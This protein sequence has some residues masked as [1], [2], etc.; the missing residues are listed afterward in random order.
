MEL[1][2]SH[3]DIK[4]NENIFWKLLLNYDGQ[5]IEDDFLKDTYLNFLLLVRE[6]SKCR[7]H[8]T[9]QKLKEEIL[10]CSNVTNTKAVKK[11]IEKKSNL[12]QELKDLLSDNEQ[13]S[14][15]ED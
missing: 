8:I 5:E 1:I 11:A 6:A 3:I 12:F 10:I 9:I 13:E 14:E 7:I 2:N 15:K 4:N